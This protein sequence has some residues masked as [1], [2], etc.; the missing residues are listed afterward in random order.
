MFIVGIISWWYGAGWKKQLLTVREKIGATIDYF[1]IGLLAKTLFSPFKQISVGRVGGPLAVQLRAFAD[2]T[3]S[4]FIGAMIRTA[5]ILAGLIYISLYTVI[6]FLSLF[7][8]AMLPL[9]PFVGIV[10]FIVGWIPWKI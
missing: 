2:R 9:L 6:G 7:A 10:L 4:R 8:W 3:I 5:V 1:S